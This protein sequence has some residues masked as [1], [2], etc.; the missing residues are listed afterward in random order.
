MFADLRGYT[1]F[2]DDHGDAA[3]A[4]L[5]RDYRKIVRTAVDRH[6]GTEVSTEGDSFFVVFESVSSAVLCGI[7]VL[8]EAGANDPPIPFG[9]G[10]HAG[11]ATAGEHGYVAGPVNI[12]AR[13]CALAKAGDLLVTDTVRALTRTAIEVRFQ[14][15]GSRRL[16]GI[17]E[18][19]PLWRI[20]VAG[21][22]RAV[23]DERPPRFLT[24]PVLAGL[25]I[26]LASVAVVVGSSLPGSPPTG[27]LRSVRLP[28]QPLPL[29]VAL[30]AMALI[31]NPVVTWAVMVR[32]PGTAR[33]AARLLVGVALITIP[34]TIFNLGAILV[35]D[36]TS[37]LAS[38]SIGFLG[39]SIIALCLTVSW[40]MVR[41]RSWVVGI[42][43]AFCALLLL[44][45]WGV[46]PL[47]V[48]GFWA[49]RRRRENVLY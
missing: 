11:E 24:W 42:G 25:A 9:V 45:I 20:E 31:V 40:G 19:V 33:I 32:H 48:A 18:P 14:S 8:A 3:A 34:V 46:Q 47:A 43:Y 30:L 16:K 23:D 7:A 15:A 49:I 13:L 1:R 10:V 27:A 12:A 4:E 41:R 29:V 5:V 44:S 36:L 28:A 2:I 38:A 17:E 21:A 6:G 35:S 26:A 22:A 37:P 39:L